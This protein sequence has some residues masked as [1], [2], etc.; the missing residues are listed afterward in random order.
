MTSTEEQTQPSP[1]EQRRELAR[2]LLA[3]AGLQGSGPAFEPVAGNGGD[4]GAPAPL[5]SAE[6]RMWFLRQLR[7]DDI[8]YNLC[9]G[10]RLTGELDHRVLAEV[11]TGLVGAHEILRT[12]YPAGEDGSPVRDVPPAA[13]VPLPL[14]D[15]GDVPPPERADEADRVIAEQGRRPFRLAAEPPLRFHLFRLAADDHLLTMT[16]HHIA[17]DD[18]SWGGVL[19][20]L[21]ARY[22]TATG[23][24]DV[25]PPAHPRVQYAD[26][27]RWECDR[28]ADGAWEDQLGYWRE[29]LLP[30]P[31]ALALPADL[32]PSGA[33]ATDGVRRDALLGPEDSRAL[34]TLARDRG[35]TLYTVLLAAYQALLHRWT[36]ESDIAVGS[37]VVTRGRAEFEDVIGNFG[38]T[39]VLRTD[40]GGDP[41]FEELL[42]RTRDTCADAFAHQD[43]PYDRVTEAL[44]PAGAVGQTPLFDA[45]FS[46][47][48][49][50]P[51]RVATPTVLFAEHPHHNGTARFPLVVE[52]RETDEGIAFGLT[53]RADLF[54]P[55]AVERMLG[56]LLTLVRGATGRPGDRLSTLPVLTAHEEHR[57][58][59]EWS[60]SHDAPAEDRPLHRLVAEQ[61]ARTPEHIA[62]VA[63]DSE[64]TYRELDRRSDELAGRLRALGVGPERVVGV[65]LSR[66]PALV[67]ALLAILKA[68]GA[69]M[70]VEPDWPA[71]RAQAVVR[72][73]APVL[74]LTDGRTTPA[75][76]PLE[77]PVIDLAAPAAPAH[78]VPPRPLDMENVAYVIHTSGSTGTPKGV[79]IRHQAI[80]NRLV[81]Q[82]ALL[83]MTPEDRVLH[84]APMGFDISVNE[85]F[86]PLVNGARLVLADPGAHGDIGHLAGLIAREKVTFLYIVASMLEVLLERED[87]S[88]EARSIR[89]LWC[90]GEALTPALYRRFRDRLDATMYHGYGPAEA[91]IG[92]SCRVFEEREDGA[93][94]TIGRP[95]PNA[96]LHLLD[97]GMRPVPVGVPGE[98]YIG[99]MPLARGYLNDPRRTAESFVPDPFG[100]GP[101]GRLYRT[102][103]LARYRADGQ[104]EFIGRVD[105]QVKVRGFRIELGEVEAALTAHPAVRQG[106]AL[107]RAGG[108]GGDRLTA[109]CVPQQEAALTTG[110]LRD[111]LTARLPHYAVPDEL[112]LVA[113][114]PLTSAGKTDRKA[115]LALA[116]GPREAAETPFIA[117]EDA[118]ERDIAA[119][120]SEL[121]DR[122]DIGVRHNF[123]DLG[124]HSLLLARAQALYHRRLG[125]ELPL[126]ELYDHPTV[127]SLAAR[128]SR[129]AEADGGADLDRVRER[130]QRQRQR[131]ARRAADA[132][133]TAQQRART[134]GE[135]TR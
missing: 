88:E 117:P 62:V 111:W 120:W 96:R 124:G 135:R 32:R 60:R 37:P 58:L 36:G 44:R 59:V 72:D 11:V 114:L 129:G 22:A 55:E 7:P 1:E 66:S 27:A 47:V 82:S 99:G 89:H 49:A 125:H 103:D 80:A 130:A 83:R 10:V 90:G 128:L 19:D 56:H 38:N 45:V 109:W 98:L 26:F 107:V 48:T 50:R 101:G 92:V 39:V 25:A 131:A 71:L 116:P 97:T 9:G 29:R 123:F 41:A 52:A 34:R 54:S 12:R 3:E 64:L 46:F 122:P 31:P 28:Q 106:V 68:G 95:N 70:P 42:L 105:S 23:G 75:P 74:V 100:S 133:R 16:V 104:I 51:R 115:L 15:L 8:A 121:L 30:H 102:G 112:H 113:A 81:W 24:C 79:M 13:E 20:E 5:S 4:G 18:L 94:V 127:A 134:P 118:L 78:A 53:A 57:A 35:V 6:R 21:A 2:L 61:A 65:H 87:I 73:A 132:A 86:L 40:L 76:P 33:A 126:V 84:K 69:F 119:I 43:I 17:F 93:V 91:T 77:V 14:T 63:R 85:I 67:V 110:A 108:P